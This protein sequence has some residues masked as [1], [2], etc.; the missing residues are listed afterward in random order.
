MKQLLIL[1]LLAGI[2][3]SCTVMYRGIRYGNADIDDYQVFDTYPL[4]QSENPFQFHVKNTKLVD[5]FNIKFNYK[6]NTYNQIDSLLNNT[7]TRSFLVIK[8]DSILYE[9][10]FRGYKRSD[11]STVFSVSKS[12]T[13][14]MVGIAVDDGYIQDIHDPVTKYI[15]EL[16][17]ADPLFKKL[18]I[19]HLL[20]MRSGIKFKEA[21][22]WNPFSLIAR[23][24]YGKN[25]LKLITK[26]KFEREP[27]TKYHYQSIATTILGIVIEKATNKNFA[28]YFEEKVWKPLEMENAANWNLDSKK[29][30]SA[31]TFGGLSISAI[32]LAKIGRLYI[33]EGRYKDKQIVSSKWISKT[34]TPNLE[35]DGYQNQWYSFSASGSDTAGTHMFP[36]SI[37]AYNVWK[38]RYAE[39]YP[40]YDIYELRKSDMKKKFHDKYW[41]YDGDKY[42]RLS[43][44]TKQFYALGIMSQLM[45]VDPEKET[46]LIRLG[47]YSDYD[48]YRSLLYRINRML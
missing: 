34:L 48:I 41:K 33:N 32:D 7:S 5:T 28:K 45:L 26:L 18:T 6:G 44:Y 24:Y 40:F 10:Y 43:L 29:Y 42:W 36:D 35:N 11:I 4:S 2:L 14:L 23:L 47:D 12:V 3:S 38:E 13:S 46:I 15:P 8:N 21:Y 20:D 9:K 19:K 16:N 27:G 30:Q 22:G 17:S 37:T 39:K 31:K 1:L 25:Q